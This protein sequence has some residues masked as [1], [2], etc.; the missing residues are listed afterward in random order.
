[1]VK[2]NMSKIEWYYEDDEDWD[3]DA[4][5][6]EAADSQTAS[7]EE[8]E[9]QGDKT[10]GESLTS[11]A[12]SSN[13]RRGSNPGGSS[14]T[15][16][17][18]FI[19]LNPIWLMTACKGILRHDLKEA[20]NSI[21]Q[22]DNSLG[23][24]FFLK[25]DCP[26]ITRSEALAL[27]R[28]GDTAVDRSI[29]RWI[30]STEKIIS[31]C[32]TP[33][34]KF[35]IKLLVT[36]NVFVPIDFNLKQT[37]LGGVRINDLDAPD[38]EGCEG[39]VSHD[40]ASSNYYFLPSLLNEYVG[41]SRDLFEFKSTDPQ[42]QELARICLAH[43]YVVND[44][45]PPG[46]MSR[47]IAS[48]LRDLHEPQFFD[49][50]RVRY[51]LRLI[52]IVC[53]SSQIL[54]C[55]N[56]CRETDMLAVAT[57]K[58]YVTMLDAELDEHQ[59]GGGFLRK[60]S[61]RL[62]VAARGNKDIVWQ[63]GFELVLDVVGRV[64]KE[65]SGLEYEREVFCPKCIE[66]D[67]ST[68]LYMVQ[69]WQKGDVERCLKDGNDRIMCPCG[70]HLAE[71]KFLLPE[72]ARVLQ[73]KKRRERTL[74]RIREEGELIES[75][76]KGVD[77][78]PGVVYILIV[79][80]GG[81]IKSAGSGFIIG[82]K[83][84]L[85]MTAAHV[86]VDLKT[87][88]FPLKGSSGNTQIFIG[89]PEGPS[90]KAA[91]KY[92]ARIV[93]YDC[94][95]DAALLKISSKLVKGV[96]DPYSLR[97]ACTTLLKENELEKDLVEL[98]VTDGKRPIDIGTPVL[99]LG[100]PHWERLHGRGDTMCLSLLK[101]S[102]ERNGAEFLGLQIENGRGNSGGPVLLNN[103]NVIGLLS[104][105]EDIAKKAYAYESKKWLKMVK[106][107]KERDKGL[108]FNQFLVEDKDI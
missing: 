42:E 84:G 1:M 65:Y 53:Y 39:K 60:G 30:K 58:I 78:F 10:T 19:F 45:Q 17:S 97:K 24:G 26:V 18:K 92:T 100:F 81:D 6:T 75:N 88:G 66:G 103:G 8:V 31:Q 40:V 67:Q 69:S 43:S 104:M 46:I 5:A 89:I 70:N 55:I 96:G 14:G 73:E 47:I 76:F 35:L 36:F 21:E 98:K 95:C 12:P 63:G 2:P 9:S 99:M 3:G 90:R 71:L 15:H 102:V 83:E 86:I 49:M 51:R 34:F 41:P 105:G 54:L 87:A 107:A 7:T 80:K 101:G 29:K 20:L 27:W 4:E 108:L 68:Q 22:E 91:F 59:I 72:A 93:Q 48:V 74:N 77:I 38:E 32:G 106:K 64:L 94:S 82:K 62:V 37:I 61:K 16:V 56:T 25:N 79:G 57:V 28:Q 50:E 44:F 13:F 52:Q 85:I 33:P 23:G 11:G